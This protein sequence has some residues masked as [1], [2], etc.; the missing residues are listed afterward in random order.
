[1]LQGKGI[2]ANHLGKLI[3][4]QTLLLNPDFKSDDFSDL[5][6]SVILWRFYKLFFKKSF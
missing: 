6:C 2:F 1:M 5:N 4:L 3:I